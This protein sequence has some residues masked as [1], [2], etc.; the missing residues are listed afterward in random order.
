M[1]ENL[2]MERFGLISQ[3]IRSETQ[4]GVQEA[5]LAM[6]PISFLFASVS[7]DIL[8]TASKRT[9]NKESKVKQFEKNGC[10]PFFKFKLRDLETHVLPPN[11]P[12]LP[13]SKFL[14]MKLTGS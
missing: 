3:E 1:V 9:Y 7:M 12:L 10:L 2:E 8:K 11:S 14:T 4:V 6:T 5:P 13:V